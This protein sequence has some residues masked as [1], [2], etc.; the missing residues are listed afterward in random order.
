MPVESLKQKTIKGIG[1]S[2][3]DNISNYAVTFFVGLILARLLT[4]DDYGLIGIVTIFTMICECF[5]RAGFGTALIRKKDATEDDYSTVFV[6][7]LFT[8]LFL[9]FVLFLSAPLIASFFHRDELISLVRVSSLGM[10]VSSFSIVQST[11]LTKRIDFKSQTKVTIAAAIIRSIVGLI[12]AFSG[13]GVWAIVGQS[14]S[15]N[16]SSTAFLCYINRWMPRFHFSKSSFK[17]LFSFGSKLLISDIITTIWNQVYSFVI[18]RCYK[19]AVLGQY[20]RAKMFDGLLSSNLTVV[21]QRV[22][23]PV[24]SELQDDKARLKEGYRRVIRATMLVSFLGS[25]MM[26]SVA[27]PMMIVLVGEQWIEASYYLQI[28][29]FSTMLFPLHSINLNMLLVL[30]RSDL[31]LKLDIIKKIIAVIPILLGIF[32]GIYWML[33]SSVVVGLVHYYINTYYSGKFLNYSFFSQIKDI[34][35]SF[36][37]SF[38]GSAVSFVIYLLLQS[39]V[40]SGYDFFANFVILTAL[41]T[42]GLVISIT[43]FE[44]TKNQEYVEIKGVIVKVKDK[45]FNR[46]QLA[47]GKL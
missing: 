10:I 41:T 47:D 18:G 33:I 30:G 46:K 22:T 3:I 17:Y 24:L 1:W 39:F 35:P 6:C 5:V 36:I 44:S 9:Y 11:R 34:M 19:P 7:N 13:L 32:I 14:L 28:V 31:F 38:A 21:V 25:L 2:A 4:P 45:I 8:S 40:Y 16:I 20:T 42:I 23:F 37:I 43:L 12:M 27:K 15:G 29:L 26:A